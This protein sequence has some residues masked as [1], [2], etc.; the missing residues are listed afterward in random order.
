MKADRYAET[1][2]RLLR[3][4]REEGT[5]SLP[6]DRAGLVAAVDHALRARSRRRGVARRSAVVVGAAVVVLAGVGLLGLRR[7]PVA[8][9]SATRDLSN[10]LIVFST[11]AGTARTTGPGDGRSLPLHQ[12]MVI[13]AGLRLTAP[14]IAEVQVG[15]TSGTALTL[16]RR[17]DLSVNEASVTQ[18]FALYAG[19]LRAHVARL[20][21]GQRFIVDTAD[22]EVEVHGTTFRVAVVAGDPACGGGARTRVSVSEGVVTVRSALGETRVAAGAEWPAGCAVAQAEPRHIDRSPQET[23]ARRPSMSAAAVALPPPRRPAAAMVAPAPESRRPETV[24]LLAKQNDLF[25]SAVR[26]KRDGR[27]EEAVETFTRL[28]ESFPRGPLVEDAM[29]QRMKVLATIDRARATQAAAAYLAR[30]PTGF[31]CDEAQRLIVR[32]SP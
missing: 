14:A 7:A 16:E 15:T 31:A 4:L 13:T 8:P 25:A 30:F 27:L 1:A 10:S 3:R 22:A 28:I 26:A 29:A 18:R 6:L 24:S 32:S 11:A 19:G 5:P 12:G 2:S 23:E 9:P 21:T 17:G 20:I